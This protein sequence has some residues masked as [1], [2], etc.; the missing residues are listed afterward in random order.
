MTHGAVLKERMAPSDA[1]SIID[2]CSI[3]DGLRV[4]GAPIGLT[5]FC[6]NFI[7]KALQRAQ[8]DTTKLLTSLDDLQTTL[9]I[10]SMC[11]RQQ[12]HP[13]IHTQHLQHQ[14]QQFTR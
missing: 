11:A 1:A 10:L 4:L 12:S 14:P 5:E 9:R 7:M 13:S 8:S 2:I 3:T 6:Q